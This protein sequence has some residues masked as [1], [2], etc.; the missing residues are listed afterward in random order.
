[1]NKL[2][3]IGVAALITSAMAMP[4]FADDR[5]T[6]ERFYTDLFSQPT[7]TELGAVAAEVLAADWK[8]YGD[9]SDFAAT[10]DSLVQ[11]LSGM[12]NIVPDLKLE[13]VEVLQDGDQY[14]VR[15][16]MTGTPVAEFLG[17][18]PTGK[19]FTIMTIDIHRVSE[20]KIVESYHVEDMAGAIRQLSTE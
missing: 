10:P 11:M 17:V 18:T 9:Y 2:I 12:G 16:R 5:K 7:S 4:S 8:S 1:M 19:S 3:A 15:S 13:I 20:G 6:V 14:I